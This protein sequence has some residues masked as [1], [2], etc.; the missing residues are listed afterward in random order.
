MN[1]Q[2]MEAA[3][4]EAEANG[5]L[6]NL[7]AMPSGM[8][9]SGMGVTNMGATRMHQGENVALKDAIMEK[10]NGPMGNQMTKQILQQLDNSREGNRLSKLVRNSEILMRKSVGKAVDKLLADNKCPEALLKAGVKV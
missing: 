9:Q 6:D 1:T 4:A 10:V 8:P 3:W 7:S 2:Q 5:E